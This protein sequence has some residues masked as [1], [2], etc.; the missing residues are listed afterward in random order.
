MKIKSEQVTT[1]FLNNYSICIYFITTRTIYYYVYARIAANPVIENIALFK[2]T[3]QSNENGNGNLAVNDR[4]N[5]DEC[6][7]TSNVRETW[8]SV[9]LQRQTIVTDVHI[10]TCGKNV[11]LCIC[12]LVAIITAMRTFIFDVCVLLMIIVSATYLLN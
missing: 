10:S 11:F 8:W 2:T 1:L 12:T 4:S 7:T 6:T 9:D 5:R 3:S